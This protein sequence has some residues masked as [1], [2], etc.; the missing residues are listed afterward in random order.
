ETVRQYAEERLNEA[1]EG[2]EVRTRHLLHYVTL[3]EQA[4]PEMLGPKQTAGYATLRHE[5]ENLLA[6][7]ARGA[8]A[9]DG[10]GRAWRLARAAG[11]YWMYSSQPAR[12]HSLGVEALKLAGGETDSVECCQLLYGMVWHALKSGRYDEMLSLA[13]RCLAMARRIG[14]PAL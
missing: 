9:P 2:D 4:A 8:H 3:A 10:G 11:R 5:Q 7:H 14:D 6:A 13:Q 1:G 12:G